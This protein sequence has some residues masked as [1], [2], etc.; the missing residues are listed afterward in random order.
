[1][2]LSHLDIDARQARLFQRLAG[3]LCVH[4]LLN[5]VGGG[6]AI[7]EVG[8]EVDDVGH[9]KPTGARGTRTKDRGASCIAMA[10]GSVREIL[11]WLDRQGSA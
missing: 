11:S 4:A 2:Q 5:Q 9:Q 6:R 1:M 10:T 3:L 7:E 8:A